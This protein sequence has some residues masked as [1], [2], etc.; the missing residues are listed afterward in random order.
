[1]LN[2]HLWQESRK[3]RQI[4]I[5]SAG[6]KESGESPQ[7]EKKFDMIVP[8]ATTN[9]GRGKQTQ[10]RPFSYVFYYTMQVTV[11]PETRIE[12]ENDLRPED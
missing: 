3:S 9:E 12:L 5:L 11:T 1:M 8:S 7:E 4:R 10:L 2:L 6:C